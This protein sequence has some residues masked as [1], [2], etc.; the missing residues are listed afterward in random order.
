[1]TT[2]LNR[3][4]AV[5]CGLSGCSQALHRV[6]S[7]KGHSYCFQWEEQAKNGGSSLFRK[8]GICTASYPGRLYSVLLRGWLLVIPHPRTVCSEEAGLESCERPEDKTVNRS[9]VRR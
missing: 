3:S 2:R 7:C 5:S 8:F 6:L 1:M 4:Y 9:R